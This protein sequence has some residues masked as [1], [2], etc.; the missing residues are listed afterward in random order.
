MK[1]E[2][3]AFS[4][5]PMSLIKRELKVPEDVREDNF[6]LIHGKFLPNTVPEEE[7]DKKSKSVHA[8]STINIYQ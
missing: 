7:R 8:V 5:W 6:L 3:A 1:D 2:M 4:Y